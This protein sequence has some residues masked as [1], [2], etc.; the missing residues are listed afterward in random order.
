MVYDIYPDILPGMGLLRPNHPLIRVWRWFNKQAYERAFA[1]LTLGDM[2]ACSLAK[3][4][5]PART[6]AGTVLVSRPWVNTALIR[7][8][9]KA[10]N[11][12]ALQNG[13][14]GKVT[15]LYS[16]NMGATHDM[17]TILEA[18]RLME[19]E[20][21]VEFLLVGAGEGYPAIQAAAKGLVNV[22]V[23]PWQPP[24]LLPYVCAAAE[25]ALVTLRPGIEMC[26]FPSKTAFALSAGSAVI[27]LTEAPSDL[28]DV[29]LRNGCG[30]V[31]RPGD[32]RNLAQ[33]VMRLVQDRGFLEECRIRARATAEAFFTSE[34]NIAVMIAG[35][36]TPIGG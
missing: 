6:A 22:R 32:P 18:A 7:P 9:L 5:N 3:Q 33:S 35:L 11:P 12:F 16:G 17:E 15:V 26:S 21:A 14:L 28:A 25:I 2:M 13:L 34:M 29:I 23:L 30:I 8:R 19:T 10:E 36:P 27:C 4:F 20:T 1:V 24:E 31:V